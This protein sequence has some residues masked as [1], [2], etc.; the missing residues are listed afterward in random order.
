MNKNLDQKVVEDF[1]KEWKKYNQ[2][3][4]NEQEL[5]S[6]FLQYFH[7]FPFQELPNDASG[8]DM[9][10]GSG[11]WAK[12]VAPRVGKLH[13]IDPSTDALEQAK[14]NARNHG[15]VT[16]HLA[17]VG[18]SVLPTNS[19]DFGYCLGVL[20]HIPDTL[21]GLNSCADLLKK[22][23]P[24]LVYLYYRFD[25]KPNWFAW[26]WRAS[27]IFR[28]LISILPFPVKSAITK[29]I[30]ISVYYPL[31]RLALLI[32]KLQVNVDNLPLADYRNK[33]FYYMRTD[34][35]DRFGTRLEK[36][37]TKKEIEAMLIASGFEALRFS[38]RTP[39]WV[40]LAY[41]A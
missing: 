38:D 41:K 13:C 18:D 23:A 10:C 5:K 8:F 28:R 21:A 27:D 6:A 2:S 37:F 20:H 32:E 3:D 35:L 7:I 29:C 12:L 25:N 30:A 39:Y 14:S 24:F 19:Q 17:S 15:N 11:R 22:G 26:L 34:A 16:F 36:R 1:G 31:A 33:S 9:G 40:V 4:L